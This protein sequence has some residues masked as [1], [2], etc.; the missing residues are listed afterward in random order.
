[1]SRDAQGV[2]K[3]DEEGA[4]P[5]V[6]EPGV[7]S[8][9]TGPELDEVA[10][11]R[12]QLAEMETRLRHV[13]SAYKQAKDEIESTKQ[14]LERNAA[15]REEIRRA[16]V[17]AAVFE[18]V[19]N[20]AR[21]IRPV[22]EANAPAAEGLHM[23]YDQFMAALHGLG[24]VEVGVEGERFDTNVHEAIHSQPVTDPASDNVVLSVFSKGYRAGTK[25]I[26]PA[27][28]VIGVFTP[29]VAEA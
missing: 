22:A 14:R 7:E 3:T 27:R 5:G 1:M 28:V 20:L 4:T 9:A 13:S 24:L 17:V 10:T 26:R 23:V 2:T 29:P 12:Q 11:L 25:L 16:E 18:P 15:V 8:S 19:E 6:D 21:S